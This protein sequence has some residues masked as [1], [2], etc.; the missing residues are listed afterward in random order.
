MPA[1]ENGNHDLITIGGAAELG[2]YV[3]FSGMTDYVNDQL[4]G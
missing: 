4:S 2:R 3:S 1:M